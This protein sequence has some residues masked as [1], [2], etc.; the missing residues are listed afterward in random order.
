MLSMIAH[1]RVGNKALLLYMMLSRTAKQR[2][3]NETLLL[4]IFVIMDCLL[5]SWE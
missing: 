2:V 1:L 4:Y 5:K 3:D